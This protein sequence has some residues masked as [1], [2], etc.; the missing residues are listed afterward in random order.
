MPYA[1]KHFPYSAIQRFSITGRFLASLSISPATPCSSTLFR[2][3]TSHNDSITVRFTDV[4]FRVASLRYRAYAFRIS[5]LALRDLTMH[6]RHITVP[7][8]HITVPNHAVCKTSLCVATPL[9]RSSPLCLYKALLH[10][11]VPFPSYTLHRFPS[12]FPRQ[13]FP[14]R[15]ETV[16][17]PCVS[18]LFRFSS[19]RCFA[20]SVLDFSE[21]ALCLAFTARIST[22]PQQLY[23]LP[24]RCFSQ[25]CSALTKRCVTFPM[26]VRSFPLL[27]FTIP[28]RY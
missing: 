8:Q 25:R 18:P 21:T 26:R 16:P 5:A 13:A 23:A 12:T 28:I 24:A 11:S 7:F 22:T 27:N 9:L 4:H 14:Y 10:V 2:D 20:A 1:S 6:I 17:L 15:I 3:V 19:I